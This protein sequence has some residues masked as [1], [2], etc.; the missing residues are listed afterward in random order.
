[1]ARQQCT[2]VYKFDELSDEAKERAVE[3]WNENGLDYEWWDVIYEDAK[4]IGALIG[5]TIKDI[6]FSGFWSQGDG[7]CFEGSYEYR[8]GSVKAVKEYAPQ[9]QELHR[10]AKDLQK[11]QRQNLYG[12]KA[13]IKQTDFHYSHEFTVSIAVE[14]ERSNSYEVEKETE[15]A[16]AEILRDF[17]RWIY[18]SLENE[19]EYQS[20]FEQVAETIRINDYEFTENGEMV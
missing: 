17:M 7:A 13:Y 5:I 12:L 15:E 14:N 6:S 10:I 20:S 8:K 16:V 18:K 19:Y 2:T 4:T 3:K 9:D 1:M 11:V